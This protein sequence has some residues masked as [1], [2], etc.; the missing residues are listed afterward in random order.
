MRSTT[1]F[2]VL[3][4]SFLVVA[5]AALTPAC[6]GGGSGGSG[7]NG[8]GG[9]GGGGAGGDAGGGNGGDAGGGSGG[10]GGDG[11]SG[12][13]AGGGAGGAAG[14][15]GQGGQGGGGTASLC[16]TTGGTVAS[17]L[18]CLATGDFPDTCSVGACGCSPNNSHTV[19]TCECQA[20]KCFD[21]VLGCVTP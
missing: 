9:S 14:Q 4:S 13:S 21:A 19:Q 16:T 7:N 5:F 2:S 11:G 15:G 3:G 12:G 1:L 8:G 6:D 17:G 18:C 10:A 20:P